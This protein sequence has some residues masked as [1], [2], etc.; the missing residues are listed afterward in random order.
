LRRFKFHLE[1]LP[2]SLRRLRVANSNKPRFMFPKLDIVAPLA[3]RPAC[4]AASEPS[5]APAQ[6]TPQEEARGQPAAPPALQ[7]V[8]LVLDCRF[9]VLPPAWPLAA[10]CAITLHAALTT[11]TQCGEPPAGASRKYEWVMTSAHVFT[12]IVTRCA[13]ESTWLSLKFQY[14]ALTYPSAP[15]PIV[16][17][18][19]SCQPW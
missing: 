7:F 6:A 10:S 19:I 18:D 11:V 12:S 9:A 8:S 2:P 3:V 5:Q 13:A 16:H 4:G 15:E 14:V 1:G 17:G